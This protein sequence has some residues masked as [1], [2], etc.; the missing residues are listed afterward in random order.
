MRVKRKVF[1]PFVTTRRQMTGG[2]GKEIGE[3]GGREGA[4][5]VQDELRLIFSDSEVDKCAPET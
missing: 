2:E 3:E 4:S 5:F 1:E